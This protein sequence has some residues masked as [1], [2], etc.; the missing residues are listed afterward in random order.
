MYSL[1]Q[2]A[3]EIIECV[4]C[5]SSDLELILTLGNQPLANSYK[6][7]RNEEQP[8][9]PLAINFCKNCNHT[10]LTHQVD[11]DLMFKDYLYVSGTANTQ[12]DYFEWFA[13]Y[14]IESTR[15]AHTVLDI[16]CNDGSQLDAY[17]KRKMI[18]YGVDPA[19]N[20]HKLSTAKGHKVYCDYFGE[21]HAKA[22]FFYDIILCQNAFAHQAH[23]LDTLKNMKKIM[24]DGSLAFIVISQSDMILNNEFDTIYHEHFSFYTISSMNAICNRAG[25]YLI[26]AVKHPIH[27]N[28]M[29]F[30]ITAN[31]RAQ[32]KA[33]ITNLINIERLNGL[34]DISTYRKF[35]ANAEKVASDLKSLLLMQ[36]KLGK[37]VIGLGAPAKGNTL[38][39]YMLMGPD[40]IL[41]ENKLKQSM[42]TPG[43]SIKIEPNDFLK[44]YD[45]IDEVCFLPLAWNFFDEMKGKMQK[46]RPGKNDVFIRYFPRLEITGGEISYHPV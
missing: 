46:L 30:T 11:P 17:K 4:A 34:H 3:E 40:F 33:N 24:H 13:E 10:Q 9:F 23:Q 25:L 20:L 19:E 6:K 18:T 45:N 39:N 16:G 32:R 44:A 41:D 7:D 5:G 43:V 36:N 26:D 1:T 38:M 8:H 28:S 14:T 42:Y 22:G 2:K 15:F 37:V 21:E 29:I 12:L 31:S 35:A 27:G